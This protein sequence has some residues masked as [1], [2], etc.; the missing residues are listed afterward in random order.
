MN[1]LITGASGLITGHFLRR[2]INEDHRIIC[3]TRDANTI[4]NQLNN[5]FQ[6]TKISLEFLR[7]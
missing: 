7:K 6:A 3:V 4:R 1:I 5:N 2:V